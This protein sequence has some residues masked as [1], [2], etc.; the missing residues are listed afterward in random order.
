M[1][2]PTEIIYLILEFRKELYIKHLE[3]KILTFKEARWHI[4]KNNSHYKS[5]ILVKIFKFEKITLPS[6]SYRQLQVLENF[7]KQQKIYIFYLNKYQIW[8]VNRKSRDTGSIYAE[9][10]LLS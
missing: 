5:T 4:Q 8:K 7:I 1:Y 10:L 6:R 2:L 9:T 3:N